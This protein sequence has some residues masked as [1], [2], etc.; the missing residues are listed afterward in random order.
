MTDITQPDRPTTSPRLQP[1]LH[2]L[3]S[4]VAAPGLVLASAD[5]QV[6]PG[7]VSGWYAGDLRLLDRLEVSVDGSALELVRADTAGA[8]RHEFTHVA[9]SLG[10]RIPDPTVTV[11]HCRELDAD[12]LVETFT[13]TSAAQ[14]PVE[15][16]LHVDLGSDLAPM[17]EVKQG[18]VPPR[19][20]ARPVPGGL[21]WR[22][23]HGGC[24]VVAEPGA[25]V[26][27]GGRFTWR[28]GLARGETLR[29]RLL[30]RTDQQGPFGP[31][32]PAP[33]SA[34]VDAEDTRVRR[35]ASQ[36][37]ADLAGLLLA[38]GGDRFLAAGSPWFLTLFGRDSLWAARMLVPFDSGLALSTLRTLARRQ[39]SAEDPA[40]EE[41]P[42]KILHEVRGG[43]LDLGDQVLPPV[44][45]GSVDA[46]P[47][48]VCTLAEAWR[49]GADEAEVRALLPAARA[50][51]GWM[52]A[53]SR[54]SG[55]LRYVDHT[56]RGLSNQGWK[57][58]HDSVQFAD[59]RLA[60]PPIAL[61]EVQAYA[62]EAAVQGVAL[63]EAFGEEPVAG[64]AEWA[65]ALRKRFDLEFWVDTDEGGH[66][67]IA[68]DRD[69]RRVDS[70]TS[71]LG[72]LLG[73]GV[74]E[75]G[76]ADRVAAVLAD[77]R[78]ASGFGLRTLSADS[79]RFSRL[80]YH[81]GTVWPHDTA[82]AVRGLA[83]EGRREEAARLA[84]GVF[85]AAEGVAYRLPELYGGDAAAD[86]SFPAAYPAACRPQAWSAAA[87]LAAL[88][89]VAGVSAD[90]A[91]GTIQHPR[92]TSTA[93]GAFS[94]RGLRVGD[95]PFDV[96]V[97]REGN[98]RLD[99][100]ADS[101]LEVRVT[102]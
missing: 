40:T 18:A 2:D 98:V 16:V 57:D 7:G 9:R 37:L 76:R 72:H 68:L 28:A 21:A 5:G 58:S 87:P 30:A 74:L 59:G 52:L 86:V 90:A 20:A 53:Q 22:S 48:F 65:A 95:R 62:Y 79:P 36:S 55:W 69:G 89:A 101:D 34:R 31:G 46:T 44:Y 73:T 100:P 39:G 60:D 24:E 61:S 12:S 14:E 10:D 47:L 8:E 3:S 85:A 27:P 64:L 102:E 38:D 75:P 56:G 41:Q 45:Y 42:G 4:C 80:S 99:L 88:V 23:E 50:C 96:H 29:V 43:D 51:L 91:T 77:P 26:D 78:L 17:S 11:D 97:D 32:R 84:E 83:A 92:R 81:G 70:V 35:T 63:L 13:V 1:L 66:V 25:E 71:N 67:A 19:A 49:W 6:R 94:V 54:E 15:I 82:V 93:L 33:W